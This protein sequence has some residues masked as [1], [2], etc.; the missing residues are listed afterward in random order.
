MSRLF[1]SAARKSSGK[2]SVAAGLCAALLRDGVKVRPFKKGPDYIDPMWLSR[3]AASPCINLDFHT[4]GAQQIRSAY[5][6]HAEAGNFALIEGNKGLFDG[7]HPDGRDS[8][9]ALA[10]LLD[11]PVVLVLDTKG[12]TRGIAPLL[13]G[14]QA[15][16][17]EVNIAGVILNNV[18]GARHESKL[19]AAVENYTDLAV[20]GAVHS[21]PDLEI[22]ERH[23][24]LITD[25]EN[26][27]A[28]DLIRNLTDAVS[29]QV[30]REALQSIA[31]RVAPLSPPPPPTPKPQIADLTIAIA[32]DAAFGFYYADDLDAFATHGARLIPFDAIHDP[33]L[34]EADGLYI[35][36]GFP[37][38]HATA[39]SHNAAM[40]ESVK[41]FV[42]RGGPVYAECGGL[43]YLSRTL[44]WNG[45]T[46]DMAGAIP[47]QIEMT[48][49][50]VGRGYMVLEET[51][52]GLWPEATGRATHLPAHEFH[53]S[54][55]AGFPKDARFA[56]RVKRGHGI[57]GRFDGL[58][59]RNTLANYAHFR[60]T[61]ANPW[62]GRFVAFVRACRG[63][64]QAARRGRRT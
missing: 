9:A 31:K 39:L 61:A 8:N 53:Y 27:A 28:A 50:P 23:L 52:R 36:G 17:P 49:R 16:D 42:R 20:V 64:E 1:L 43:M 55:P 45:K 26:H 5:R 34:P 7:L 21:N 46:W 12:M 30:D 15:F 41:G 47:A 18:G 22:V 54:R 25:R 11:T 14:Y 32:R 57:N 24:G 56:Y 3:A 40:R 13:L 29:A 62:V 6:R 4:M 35:G 19:R 38:T 58:V 33:A 2:T 63:G 51:G 48:D 37:E 59:H 10:K 44:A 60:N